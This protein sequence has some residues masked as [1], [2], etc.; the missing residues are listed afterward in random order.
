MPRAALSH[1]VHLAAG[2]RHTCAIGHTAMGSDVQNKLAAVCWGHNKSGQSVV[3]PE[4]KDGTLALAA[5]FGHSCGLDKNSMLYCWGSN[6]K[7]Q[8]D[9]GRD[10]GA[11]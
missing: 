5:G 4:F 2:G 10:R 3:P 7:F 9:I 6:D 11:E 8:C 1:V